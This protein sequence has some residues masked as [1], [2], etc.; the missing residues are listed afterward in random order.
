MFGG[1]SPYHGPPIRFTATQLQFMPEQMR[2]GEQLKLIDHSEMFVLD[3]SPSLKTLCIDTLASR[4]REST[5]EEVG[6]AS[7]G[8]D[9]QELAGHLPH[10]LMEDLSNATVPNKISEPLPLLDQQG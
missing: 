9:W 4:W 8:P 2:D 1:T 5:S 6:G 10:S 7:G 3:L